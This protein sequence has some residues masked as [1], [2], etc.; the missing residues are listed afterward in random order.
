MNFEWKC[1]MIVLSPNTEICPISFLI[2]CFLKKNQLEML[3]SWRE[4]AFLPVN[5]MKSAQ[6]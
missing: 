3:N 6:R 4:V 1:M 2:E 5:L